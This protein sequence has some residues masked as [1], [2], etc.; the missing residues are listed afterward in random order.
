L[1][2]GFVRGEGRS[3]LAFCRSCDPE[4]EVNACNIGDAVLDMD[5]DAVTTADETYPYISAH[6]RKLATSCTVA[7]ELSWVWLATRP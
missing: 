2:P 4:C 5:N 3:F 1:D 6:R 7:A